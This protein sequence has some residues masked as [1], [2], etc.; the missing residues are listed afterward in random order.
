MCEKLQII[1]A[2]KKSKEII[3]SRVL[4]IEL[5]KPPPEQL[6]PQLPPFHF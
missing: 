1:Y 2:T 4:T 6:R 3:Y 5:K